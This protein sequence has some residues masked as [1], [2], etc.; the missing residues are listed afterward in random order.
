MADDTSRKIEAILAP[1]ADKDVS[2][3]DSLAIQE[4]DQLE[5]ASKQPAYRAER[6]V[7]QLVAELKERISY[8]CF[9][10]S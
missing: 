7:A 1:A 5:R 2:A 9:P 3:D 6:A 10:T 8:L 4:A